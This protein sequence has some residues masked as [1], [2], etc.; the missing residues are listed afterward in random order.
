MIAR[1]TNLVSW[2]EYRDTV[3][4]FNEGTKRVYLFSGSAKDFWLALAESV[5]FD[6]CVSS[7]CTIYGIECRDIICADL[8]NFISE[9]AGYG[10]V[11]VFERGAYGEL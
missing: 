11:R 2:Q 3:Y 5:N 1:F 7:L 10:L 9:I 6:A 8:K 4:A